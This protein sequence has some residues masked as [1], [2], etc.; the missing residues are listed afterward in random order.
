[1]KSLA[2]VIAALA[3][4]AGPLPAEP[5]RPEN[6]HPLGAW[7]K[8]TGGQW[9][10]KGAW[11][12]GF[13]FEARMVAKW[14]PDKS[15]LRV[16]TFVPVEDGEFIHS[17]SIYFHHP[18][19]KKLTYLSTISGGETTRAE[20]EVSG[21][22]VTFV[23]PA[24]DGDAETKS[25]YTFS[26]ADTFR[27]RSFRRTDEG[28]ETEIDVGF[29]RGDLERRKLYRAKQPEPHLL[30]PFA[31]LVG[32]RW[33]MT[34][35]GTV[36]GHPPGRPDVEGSQQHA[37]GLT[38]QVME[39]RITEPGYATT[40]AFS[41]WDA[42]GER[43]R[44][45]GFYGSGRPPIVVDGTWSV[46]GDTLDLTYGRYPENWEK[47]LGPH[48]GNGLTLRFEGKDS[49]VWET[50]IPGYRGPAG[51]RGKAARVKSE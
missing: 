49:L 12:D 35:E 28:W 45:L 38:H 47:R 6:A 36:D 5:E 34:L 43:F 24:S 14:G 51:E 19:T 27:Y 50:Q 48:E 23:H 13:P 8:L 46:E 39:S 37:W 20:F 18:K 29:V 3:V 7:T 21:D 22:T 26:K 15:F 1:M 44:F 25:V 11:S 10:A 4:T 2:V 41:W 9:T 31:R 32:G 17:D 30:A 42:K 16:L 40:V 33:R